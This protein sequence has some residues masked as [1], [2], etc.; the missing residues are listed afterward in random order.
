MAKTTMFR[1]AQLVWCDDCMRWMP[2]TLFLQHWHL[3]GNL[4]D[5]AQ[6]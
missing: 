4:R 1:A 3:V 6:V 5:G 2:T